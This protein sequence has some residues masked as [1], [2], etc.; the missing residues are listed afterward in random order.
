MTK[1]WG[2]ELEKRSKLCVLKKLVSGG[3]EARCV[4]VGRKMIR[5]I[6]MKL[7][8]GGGGGTAELQAEVGRWRGLRREER[9][10]TE[11][12]SAWRGR[13]CEVLSDEM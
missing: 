9:K 10:C 4:G 3:F 6:L 2:K 11:C 1:L 8:K 7:A 13:G 12:D 5:R